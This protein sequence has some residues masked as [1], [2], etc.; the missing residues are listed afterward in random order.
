MRDTAGG[1]TGQYFPFM[2]EDIFGVLLEY[3]MFCAWI[4]EGNIKSMNKQGQ[5]NQCQTLVFI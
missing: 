4:F 1:A 2:K 5:G 3:S